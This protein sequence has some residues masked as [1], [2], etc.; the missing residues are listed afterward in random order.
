MFGLLV[1]GLALVGALS[2]FRNRKAI[3]SRIM[4]EFNPGISWGQMI[5][6][7]MVQNSH[8][9]FALKFVG[10]PDKTQLMTVLGTQ[11]ANLQLYMPGDTVTTPPNPF[12]PEWLAALSQGD[13]IGFGQWVGSA[14]G[15][16]GGMA[17]ASLQPLGLDTTMPPQVWKSTE[18]YVNMHTKR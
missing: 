2:I 18:D 7:V 9:P 12:P 4:S 11:F 6:P 5:P 16:N 17:T 10:K 3:E 15:S 14:S 8:Y 1:T 13:V